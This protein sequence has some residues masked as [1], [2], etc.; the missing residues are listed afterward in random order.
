MAMV[1]RLSAAGLAAAL[2][3]GG[4]ACRHSCNTAS[5]CGTSGRLMSH[6]KTADACYDPFVGV[7]V[8]GAPGVING[9]LVPGGPGGVPMLPGPTGVN[10]AELPYPQPSNIP[11]AGVPFAPPTTAPGDLGAA[12]LPTPKVMQSVKAEK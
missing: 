3:T 2:L 7:P 11:P 8:S 10:P 6:A 12:I 1:R 9:T 4:T 5:S